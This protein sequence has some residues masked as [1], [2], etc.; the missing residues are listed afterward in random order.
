M[1]I[2]PV[3]MFYRMTTGDVELRF[4]PVSETVPEMITLGDIVDREGLEELLR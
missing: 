4:S 3:S 2:T 1:V